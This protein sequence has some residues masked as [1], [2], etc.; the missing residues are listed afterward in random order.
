M[1]STANGDDDD[2]RIAEIDEILSAVET[3]RATTV[4]NSLPALLEPGRLKDRCPLGD[5]WRAWDFLTLHRRELPGGI[6]IVDR[7]GLVRPRVGPIDVEWERG[8][9]DGS[10]RSPTLAE[11]AG[12]S[13]RFTPGSPAHAHCEF[14]VDAHRVHIDRV[15]GIKYGPGRSWI[16][17]LV[18]V[19]DVWVGHGW[20]G[21]CSLGGGGSRNWPL[22]VALDQ[23]TGI[24][25]WDDGKVFLFRKRTVE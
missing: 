25:A 22:A 18:F 2:L 10:L 24:Q 12:V 4:T 6:K 9:H 7:H 3:S 1:A 17:L 21:G 5:A 14:D 13:L 8:A 16:E 23:R 15:S 19:D 11:G 20:T